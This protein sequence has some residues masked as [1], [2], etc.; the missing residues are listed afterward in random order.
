M[1]YTISEWLRYCGYK[2][3]ARGKMQQKWREMRCRVGSLVSGGY[4][5]GWLEC[6]I[7]LLRGYMYDGS[8]W[9]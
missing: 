7:P 1:L 3:C 9:L 4:G 5:G 6:L 2:V 8:S